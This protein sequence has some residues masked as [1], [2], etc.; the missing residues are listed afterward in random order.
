MEKSKALGQN[1]ASKLGQKCQLFFFSLKLHV[2][3]CFVNLEV[4][5]THKACLKTL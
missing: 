5:I 2:I 1:M 3:Q 4:I